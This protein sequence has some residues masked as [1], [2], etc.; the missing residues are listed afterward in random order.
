[1]VKS[2]DKYQNNWQVPQSVIVGSESS[3]LEKLVA[4]GDSIFII[5]AKAYVDPYIAKWD[6]CSQKRSISR[7]S[8][9]TTTLIEPNI[10]QE[11]IGIAKTFN[12]YLH[13]LY[14]P[15]TLNHSYYNG[16]IWS[17]P[18]QINDYNILRY[19][20]SLSSQ[21]NDLYYFWKDGGSSYIKYRQY[22]A[23]PLTPKDFTGIVYYTGDNSHP[24][25][26]WTLNNEPDVRESSQGYVIWRKKIKAAIHKLQQ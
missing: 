22:N 5:F 11:E 15:G 8:W 26:Q 14:K 17:I 4:R 16:Y 24:K 7:T 12:N 9:S 23:A 19:G 25:I 3:A 10:F 13:I 18:V 21:S 1:M 2:R 20:L 6:I